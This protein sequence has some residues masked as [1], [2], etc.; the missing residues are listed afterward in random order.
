MAYTI[1]LLEGIEIKGIRL[2]NRISMPAMHVHFSR[3]G[4]VNDK[5]IEYYRKRA[6]GEVGLIFVGV[7]NVDPFFEGMGGMLQLCDDKYIDGMK[8]LTDVVHEYG[9]RIILQITARYLGFK[10]DASLFPYEHI[11]GMIKSIETGARRAYKAGFDGVELIGS[12]GSSLS[13]FMSKTNPRTDEYGGSFENRM[14]FAE[15]SVKA[16]REGI[17]DK[18]LSFRMHGHE[19]LE[20]GY[21][22]KEAREIA[23]L[24]EKWGV[25][26]INITG[27][28]HTTKVPQITHF[29]PPAGYAFLARNI[30]DVVNIPVIASNRFQDPILA[31]IYLIK[32]WADMVNFA[33]ALHADPYLPKKLREGNYEDIVPCIACSQ[34]CFDRIVEMNPVL[35]LVNPFSGRED[36]IK[37]EKTKKPKKVVVLGGGPAGL[38]CARIASLRGH[39]VILYE[40][41]KFIG[42]NFLLASRIPEKEEFLKFIQWEKRQLEKNGVEIKIDTEA[43]VEKIKMEKPDV[44][45][46]A[47]GTKPSI[48]P[49]KGIDRKNVFLATD[50][51]K[52]KVSVGENVVI[53]GG[54]AT[55]CEVAHYIAKIDSLA[56]EVIHFLEHHGYLK[57]DEILPFWKKREITILE[58][59]PKIGEG[60]GRSTRWNILMELRRLGVKVVTDAKVKEIKENE[61]IYEV[62]GEEKSVK[63]DTVLLATGV[64]PNSEI[65]EVMKDYFKEVYLIGDAKKPGD[66]LK[67]VHDGAEVALR[68]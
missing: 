30:K 3:D 49:I 8:K 35:C 44:V 40:K 5:Y 36:E 56:P 7:C 66:A 13:A 46:V 34:G 12:G 62:N 43:T 18:I 51:L 29:V 22:L 39:K 24:L 64:K 47:T 55:G 58:M 48:P 1:K 68:I 38:E 60:I 67:A 45:V 17:S 52:G 37:M 21:E 23:V 53:I 20:G 26:I 10:G 61:V 27:G 63:A 33:R 6:E 32:G 50:V 41:E 42:G 11:D 16:A 65:Y 14:R 54:G 31:D 25:D 2:R 28:G 9:A 4:F 15:R 19:F 59:L 57:R